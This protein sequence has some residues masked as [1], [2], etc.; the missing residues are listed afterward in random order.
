MTGRPSHLAHRSVQE[1][2]ERQQAQR[3]AGGRGVE[4]DA[5]ELGV[6]L[7]FQ[8]LDHLRAG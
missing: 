2:W 6:L 4:D 1:V 3:V 5:R 7:V 8:K